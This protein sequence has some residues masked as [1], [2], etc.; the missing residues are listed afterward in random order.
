MHVV[1]NPCLDGM[2][3]A[4]SV[5]HTFTGAWIN[6]SAC[7]AQCCFNGKVLLWNDLPVE[8]PA[9]YTEQR[10]SPSQHG[11]SAVRLRRSGFWPSYSGH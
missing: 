4:Y 9:I 1:K 2:I 6:D 8:Q 3:T 5:Q 11:D 7:S 10:M